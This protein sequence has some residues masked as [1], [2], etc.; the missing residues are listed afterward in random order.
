MTVARGFQNSH[1][2]AVVTRVAE[3]GYASQLGIEEGDIIVGIENQWI[4]GYDDFLK[5]IKDTN[6]YPVSLVIRRTNRKER[7]TN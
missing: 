6:K 5:K 7:N 3:N 4:E 2:S 1:R